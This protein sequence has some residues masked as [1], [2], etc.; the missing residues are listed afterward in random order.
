MNLLL[1]AT[2]LDCEI[3]VV[4]IPC[5]SAG[6]NLRGHLCWLRMRKTAFGVMSQCSAR[7]CGM[8][9]TFWWV[10]CLRLMLVSIVTACMEPTAGKWLRPGEQQQLTLYSGVMKTGVTWSRDQ[11]SSTILHKS[12]ASHSGFRVLTRPGIG[13]RCASVQVFPSCV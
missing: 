5:L 1:R 9:A 7:P 11:D 6:I 2:I 13:C 12:E 3:W 8:V 10:S 4:T